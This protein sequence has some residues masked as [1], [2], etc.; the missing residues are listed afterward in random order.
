MNNALSNH[1]SPLLRRW[2]PPLFIGL[3]R[4]E[5]SSQIT[6]IMYKDR[7]SQSSSTGKEKELHAEKASQQAPEGTIPLSQIEYDTRLAWVDDKH[8]LT[9]KDNT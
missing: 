3:W 8:R 9:E 6:F 1:A 7:L 4:Y 2:A 5:S